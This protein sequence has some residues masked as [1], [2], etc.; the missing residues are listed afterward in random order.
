MQLT[1]KLL[2]DKGDTPV[3]RYR[4]I[5]PVS[6][7]QMPNVE[8]PARLLATLW[9]TEQAVACLMPYVRV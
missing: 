6:T 8:K 7:S 9:A 2:N 1:Q 5:L 4:Y 3:S